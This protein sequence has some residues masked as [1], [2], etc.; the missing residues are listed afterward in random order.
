M[1][2]LGGSSPKTGGSA[3]LLEKSF[4]R[5]TS[6]PQGNVQKSL[7]ECLQYKCCTISWP[8][9]TYSFNSSATKTPENTEE[10]Y[11]DLEQA[12]GGIQTEHSDNLDN[13]VHVWSCMSLINGILLHILSPMQLLA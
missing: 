1:Q 9:V 12:D 3:F 11:D 10:N 6:R 13:L 7:Q 5:E 4:I 8:L 2:H